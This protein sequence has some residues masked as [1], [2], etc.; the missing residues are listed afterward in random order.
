LGLSV[1]LSPAADD[2]LTARLQ[3]LVSEAAD[4]NKQPSF[5]PHVTLFWAQ[6]DPDEAK[7]AAAC[8]ALAAGRKQLELTLQ[9]LATSDTRFMCIYATV[10]KGN[11]DLEALRKA[12]E[13]SLGGPAESWT[14]HLSLVYDLPLEE[15]AAACAAHSL[16]KELPSKLRF[17]HL[18]LWEIYER[19][20]L[21]RRLGSFALGGA[22]ARSGDGEED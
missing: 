3:Q 10:D 21:W 13:A 20:D 17:S 11:A 19:V 8:K 7:L 2:P 14:P 4:A 1:W 22:T 6:G 18:T 9:A 5:E 15:R 16:A 12:C